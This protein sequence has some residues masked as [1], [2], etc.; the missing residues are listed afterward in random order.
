MYYFQQFDQILYTFDENLYDYKTVVDI[1]SR[2]DVIPAV[3]QNSLI[4]YPYSVKD[5]DDAT[6]I[7]F[8]YYGDSLRHWIVFFANQ[9]VDPYFDM[10]LKEAD[11]ENNIILAYGSLENAQA[12][13]YQVVQYVNVTTTFGGTSNTISYVSS[14][15]D[16]YSYNFATNALEPITLPSI[17]FPVINKGSTTVTFPNGTVVTTDTQ[18]VAQSAYDYLVAQNESKRQIQL[19]DKQYASTLETELTSLLSS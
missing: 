2:V 6:I 1:F 10:P 9:V 12:N 15:E 18:W 4:Y 5:S 11:L 17:E 8:K 16:T 14:I 3:L 7:A 13:L 19:I